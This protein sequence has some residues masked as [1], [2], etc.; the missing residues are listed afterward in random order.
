MTEL[1]ASVKHAE[2]EVKKQAVR[3]AQ[4]KVELEE[5]YKRLQADMERK[6]GRLKTAHELEKL[7]LESEKISLEVAKEAHRKGFE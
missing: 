3:T 7:D 2:L 6:Y 1:E 4:T 5:G